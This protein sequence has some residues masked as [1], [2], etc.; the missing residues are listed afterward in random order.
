MMN[1]RIFR[2]VVLSAPAPSEFYHLELHVPLHSVEDILPSVFA[3]R[4][5]PAEFGISICAD[6]RNR[7]SF[8]LH[9]APF[10]DLQDFSMA[11]EEIRH[12]FF[13]RRSRM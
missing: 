7:K 6:G 10:D 3:I 13:G 1:L 12:A 5:P 8:Y 9:V 4:Q 11:L 2:F